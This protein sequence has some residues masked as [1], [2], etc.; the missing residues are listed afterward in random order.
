MDWRKRI[1][2]VSSS[3]DCVQSLLA[4]LH[5]WSLEAT[6]V[7]TIEQARAVV[8]RFAPSLVIAEEQLPDGRFEAMLEILSISK[9]PARLLVVL[10]DETQYAQALRLG[11]FAVILGS[12]F[13]RTDAQ[14][15]LIQALRSKPVLRPRPAIRDP[16][17]FLNSRE[18]TPREESLSA[19]AAKPEDYPSR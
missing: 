12:P 17:P 14:W 1:L 19:S 13:Q 2:I 3:S 9:P 10:H 16:R 7:A 11:A 5:G 4:V 15:A 8:K 18:N 6:V